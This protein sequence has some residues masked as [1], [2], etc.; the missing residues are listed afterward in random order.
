MVTRDDRNQSGWLRRQPLV[1]F[2]LALAVLSGCAGNEPDPRGER[3]PVS[4]TVTLD[5]KPVSN[6][7]ILFRSNQGTGSVV[8]T[9]V[10]SAG[11]YSIPKESGPVPGTAT[12]KVVAQMM[13]LED[14]EAVRGGDPSRQVDMSLTQI[15]DK[16]GK[17]STLKAGVE[18]EGENKFDFE[19]T[20]K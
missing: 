14:L 1:L 12:V 2:G 13:E 6:A 8:A 9:A 3:V 15:P 5:D 10:I 4:G 7:E 17:H 19:L 16:Y 18:A 20:S 11:R